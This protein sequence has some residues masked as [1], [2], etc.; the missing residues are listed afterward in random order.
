MSTP[1]RARI[2]TSRCTTRPARRRH[3][4][5]T[6]PISTGD[7]SYTIPQ[8][9][10]LRVN[11]QDAKTLVADYD[12]G[13]Q[14]LVYSTSEIMTHLQQGGKDIALLHGRDGEDGETVLRYADAPR[15]QGALR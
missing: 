14:H 10:T 1:T 12:F 5:F 4:T 6:F 2:S 15:C 11:G 8:T 13:G 9:G 7:G 3:D